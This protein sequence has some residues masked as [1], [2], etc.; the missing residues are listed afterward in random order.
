MTDITTS[1]EG[2]RLCF[3]LCLL[4][5]PLDYSI[6]YEQISTKFFGGVGVD[7]LRIG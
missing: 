6:N 5:C 3:Y 4:V 1:A 2:K 7:Q